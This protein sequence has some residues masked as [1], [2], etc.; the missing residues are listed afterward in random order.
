MTTGVTVAIVFT[1]TG[2]RPCS[3]RGWP[4]IST[5]GL[6]TKVLYQTTTGAGF[7]VPITTVT[8]EP[9]QTAASALDLFAAPGNTY[10]SCSHLGSWAI[11]PPG[12]DHPSSVTWPSDQG[13]C[14]GGTV[15]VSPVYVGAQPEVGF[16]S[17]DP[18]SVPVL[19]PFSSPPI[20]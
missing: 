4:T 2:M 7:V 16:G 17:L 18:A 20:V 14:D 1:N 15:L 13:P 6:A 12:A 9:E 3:L 11:S 19:G 5:P 8:L 10:G